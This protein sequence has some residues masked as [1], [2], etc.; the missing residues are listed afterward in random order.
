MILFEEING[1]PRYFTAN[2]DSGSDL[3]ANF[4][5]RLIA[6][7]TYILRIRLYWQHRAGDLGVMVW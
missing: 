6:G 4:K 7:R 2:D 1:Q 3:N 5:L